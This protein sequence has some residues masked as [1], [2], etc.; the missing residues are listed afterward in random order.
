[1]NV[2]PLKFREIPDGSVLFSDDAG[3]FFKSSQSFLDRYA[4]DSLSTV[5][6][7]FFREGNHG[8]D[9]EFDLPWTSFAYR[10]A[11]RQ[12]KPRRMNYVILVPDAQVQSR[13]WVLRGFSGF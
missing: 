5:D 8:F 13:L 1:M 10:W 11:R 7:A 4:T 2:W 12:S 3:G 9:Q 6:T